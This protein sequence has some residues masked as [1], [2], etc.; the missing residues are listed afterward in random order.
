MRRGETARNAVA[1]LVVGSARA[2]VLIGPTR[3]VE[4]RRWRWR[5]RRFRRR[6]RW[7]HYVS[8]LTAGAAVVLGKFPLRAEGPLIALSNRLTCTSRVLDVVGTGAVVLVVPARRVGAGPLLL[9]RNILAADAAVQLR[10]AVLLSRG[11]H[12][13]VGK[14]LTITVAVCQV[15]LAPSAV[16]IEPVLGVGALRCCGGQGQHR[17]ADEALHRG[18]RRQASSPPAARWRPGARGAGALPADD[19]HTYD[20]RVQRGGRQF[21]RTASCLG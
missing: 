20:T 9:L 16:L 3:C 13:A 11:P 10:V 6:R 5:R 4:A 12:M 21:Q 1:L 8:W 15:G 18:T 17:H 2:T 19:T 14:S 7:R